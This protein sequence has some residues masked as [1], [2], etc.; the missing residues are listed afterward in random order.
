MIK[1]LK[2]IFVLFLAVCLTVTSIALTACKD[3]KGDPAED[4]YTVE[5]LYPDNKPVKPTDSGDNRRQVSATL[6]DD[7]GKQLNKEDGT[8]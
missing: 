6:L 5:V 3:D 8:P 4:G 2:S 1:S 7:E